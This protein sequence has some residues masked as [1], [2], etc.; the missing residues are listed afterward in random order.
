MG[1]ENYFERIKKVISNNV[2]YYTQK[3]NLLCNPSRDLSRIQVFK[4]KSLK[5]NIN[6]N[7]FNRFSCNHTCT[8]LS[9]YLDFTFCVTHEK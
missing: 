6:V 9:I 4:K 1:Y 3:L 2:G 5:A 7:F 8:P